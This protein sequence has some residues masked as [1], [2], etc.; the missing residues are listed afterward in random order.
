MTTNHVK[1]GGESIPETSPQITNNS[2]HKYSTKTKNSPVV[3]LCSY[4]TKIPQEHRIR[5]SEKEAICPN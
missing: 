1:T 2:Q 4:I 5:R 3:K